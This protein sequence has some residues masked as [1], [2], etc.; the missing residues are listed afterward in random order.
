[1]AE[2]L[3]SD[4]EAM[5]SASGKTVEIP[6]SSLDTWPFKF[7]GR[8]MP[9]SYSNFNDWYTTLQGRFN[10]LVRNYTKLKNSEKIY[11]KLPLSEDEL[12]IG[13]NIQIIED[14]IEDL[15]TTGPNESSAVYYKKISV[16]QTALR[17]TN[18]LIV[19]TQDRLEERKIKPILAMSSAPSDTGWSLTSYL[20][21]GAVGVGAWYSWKK[22]QL[23]RRAK[24]YSSGT[25]FNKTTP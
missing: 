11:G 25:P 8:N 4:P 19:E 18:S 10:V 23:W 24:L 5:Y 7:I 21:L 1:M 9:C 2:L 15:K 12:A 20:L 6:C 22:F 13:G 3:V 17:D 14:T 16:V